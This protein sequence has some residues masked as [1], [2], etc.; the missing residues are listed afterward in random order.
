MSFA[1]V[2]TSARNCK[3]RHI[4]LV[5]ISMHSDPLSPSHNSPILKA[6][7]AFIST[8]VIGVIEHSADSRLFLFF[9]R[10]QAWVGGLFQSFSGTPVLSAQH[11]SEIVLL[12]FLNFIP[13]GYFCYH[14]DCDK[15][16]IVSLLW[17]H[18][19]HHWILE[20]DKVLKNPHMVSSWPQC[21]HCC[22]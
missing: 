6:A 12:L 1:K 2:Q 21:V 13:L 9:Y 3:A 8:G 17:W 5:A 19:L 4:F 16:N 11:W 20:V 10:C 7:R 18:V 22:V 14:C 15:A